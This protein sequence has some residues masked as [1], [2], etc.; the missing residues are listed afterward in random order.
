MR[1]YTIKIPVTNRKI[2]RKFTI[3]IP[4]TN[5]KIMRKCTIKIPVTNRKTLLRNGFWTWV[6]FDVTAL[7]I[8]I[9]KMVT[10]KKCLKSNQKINII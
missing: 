10:F 1:K 3:K 2:M 4:V 6:N 5:R 7:L 9:D 8:R